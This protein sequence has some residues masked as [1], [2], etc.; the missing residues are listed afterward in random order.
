MPANSIGRSLC[1]LLI[2]LQL[3]DAPRFARSEMWLWLSGHMTGFAM[4]ILCLTVG[5]LYHGPPAQKVIGPGIARG[6]ILERVV[7]LALRCYP[8]ARRD[9]VRVA[10]RRKRRCA[11]AQAVPCHT[12]ASSMWTSRGL[13]S[14]SSGGKASCREAMAARIS[15]HA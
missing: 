2:L 3:S 5:L 9:H 10:G 7:N 8:C 1:T 6:L 12:A 13:T 11:R 4:N 14:Q 15:A